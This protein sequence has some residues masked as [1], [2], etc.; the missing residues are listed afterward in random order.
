MMKAVELATMGHIVTV[1]NIKQKWR[2]RSV[3][4]SDDVNAV[5]EEAQRI[6]Q[7]ESCGERLVREYFARYP[8]VRRMYSNGATC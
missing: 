4:S 7:G 8:Q 1:V 2:L 6:L 5:N 3:D